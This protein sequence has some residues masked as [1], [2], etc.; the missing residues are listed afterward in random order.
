METS[1][2]MVDLLRLE[3]LVSLEGNEI[4][5]T[6][7]TFGCAVLKPSDERIESKSVCRKCNM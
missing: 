1:V 7:E 5:S 3:I 4:W 6:F 2:E